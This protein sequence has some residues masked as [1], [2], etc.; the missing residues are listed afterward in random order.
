MAADDRDPELYTDLILDR[1]DGSAVA[2]ITE[3]LS[4]RRAEFQNE[5]Y[6]WFPHTAQYR[7]WFDGMFAVLADRLV[8]PSP[9]ERLEEIETAREEDHDLTVGGAAQ[10][11]D[12]VP[13][14]DP[15]R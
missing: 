1:L 10:G 11:D 13:G 14:A 12:A 7:E 15:T 6:H 5:F 4:T 9:D 8:G 2:F 3:Q